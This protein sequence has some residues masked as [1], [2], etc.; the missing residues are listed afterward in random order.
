MEIEFMEGKI[1]FEKH[2]NVLDEMALRFSGYLKRAGIDHA[3]LSGYVAILFGRNRSSE[4]IDVVCGPMSFEKFTS[5]WDLVHSD[6]ECIITS[7]NKEAFEEYLCQETAL[8][9]AM[10]GGFI[11]NVEMFIARNPLHDRA[12]A[13]SI[14]VILN[15]TPLPISPLEQQIAY[16]VYMGSEKDL[17]DARFLFKL[18]EERLD[19]AAI[20]ELLIDL[21]V[22]IEYA[23]KI[24]GWS[25]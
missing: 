22:N 21:D 16:K 9:F 19:K 3:F 5:L 11:P 14:D 23:K 2:L 18:M 6:M 4:D 10:K 24:L 8:R 7:D 1:E 12:I 17:E 25:A 20:H 13:E 15:G